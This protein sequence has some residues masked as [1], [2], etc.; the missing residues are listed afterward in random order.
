MAEHK[1]PKTPSERI[2]DEALTIDDGKEQ[3]R[4]GAR[5]KVARE[6]VGLLQEDVALALGIPRASVSAL[7]SGKRR[8]TGLEVRRLARIYRRPVG[9]LLGEEDVEL[10]EAEPLF[11]AAEALSER[12]RDQVLRFAEFL[13]AAGRPAASGRAATRPSRLPSRSEDTETGPDPDA[14]QR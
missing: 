13:A 4:I 5:L 1:R 12:D 11:R 8:V 2:D 9:W 6:Y 10:S 7:E 3:A 14:R